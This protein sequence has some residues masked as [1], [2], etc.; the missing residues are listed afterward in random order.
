MY[1]TIAVT[2]E[3]MVLLEDVMIRIRKVT[4]KLPTKRYTLKLVLELAKE[5]DDALFQRFVKK[6]MEESI[7]SDS[8]LLES[9]PI[10][11]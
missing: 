4:K 10:S 3:E 8:Y 11:T 1:T 9:E 2:D 7:I 5:L 6:H